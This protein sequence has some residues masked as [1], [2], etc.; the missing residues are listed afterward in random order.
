MKRYAT[1]HIIVTL[2]YQLF[3]ISHRWNIY[4]SKICK[5][6]CVYISPELVINLYASIYQNTNECVLFTISQIA[7]MIAMVAVVA[8]L[9]VFRRT[10]TRS[11]NK[12]VY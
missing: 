8:A 12:S 10:L 4:T 7:V 1:E 11:V 6:Y 3:E 9:L 5:C 2:C